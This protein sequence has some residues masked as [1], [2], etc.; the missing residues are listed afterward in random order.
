M[1]SVQSCSLLIANAMLRRFAKF[2]TMAEKTRFQKHLHEPK[3]GLIFC[4]PNGDFVRHMP[5]VEI[6]NAI[7]AVLNDFSAFTLLICKLPKLFKVQ[8]WPK[9]LY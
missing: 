1:V 7:S 2:R 5:C 9:V 3:S 8:A 4:D 6:M